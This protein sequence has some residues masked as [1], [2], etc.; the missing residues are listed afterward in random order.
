M[1]YKGALDHR[2]HKGTA[3]EDIRLRVLFPSSAGYN[4]LTKLL[5]KEE[6]RLGALYSHK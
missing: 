2:G 1:T 6:T 4:N 3:E 5:P